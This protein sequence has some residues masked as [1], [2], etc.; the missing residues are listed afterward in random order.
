MEQNLKAVPGQDQGP[1]L[2]LDLDPTRSRSGRSRS[3]SKQIDP[4]T[5]E[6]KLMDFICVFI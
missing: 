5:A 6:V 2:V 1:G 3:R 4:Y